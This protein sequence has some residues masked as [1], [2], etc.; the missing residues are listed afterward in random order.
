MGPS[1][2]AIYNNYI[3]RKIKLA[4]PKERRK[5][6]KARAGAFAH[7]GS[8]AST[9]KY[10]VVLSAPIPT[11]MIISKP[12]AEP[13]D[14]VAC[15]RV[16]R[17]HAMMRSTQEI[18]IWGR[19]RFVLATV[20]PARIPAGAPIREAPSKRTPE[21]MGDAPLHAFPKCQNLNCMRSGNKTDLEPDRLVIV[22]GQHDYRHQDC[23]KIPA[24][25]GAR[26]Y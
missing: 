18:Q 17:P 25:T 15:N 3:R 11:A 7:S 5:V 22:K 8:G 1:V 26:C 9:G 23:L 19:Y 2:S 16:K 20:A 13:D 21:R 10:V 12:I 24:K 14:V 4:W 6:K